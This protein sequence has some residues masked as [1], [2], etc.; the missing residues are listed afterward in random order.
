MKK[1]NRLDKNNNNNNILHLLNQSK[2]YPKNRFKNL[3][4][5]DKFSD[6]VEETNLHTH[7]PHDI[8][9]YK[10]FLFNIVHAL[11]S[12]LWKGDKDNATHYININI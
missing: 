8:T 3:F 1:N 2:L 7:S 10:T 6:V 9:Y 12:F 4:M 11:A 5:E